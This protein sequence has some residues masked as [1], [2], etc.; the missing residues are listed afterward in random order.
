MPG[1]NRKALRILLPI[2]AADA[3]VGTVETLC[4][5]SVK[6]KSGRKQ[7]EAGGQKEG[8]SRIAACGPAGPRQRAPA[9][10]LS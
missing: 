3:L 7:P 1:W 2:V 5:M 9:P 10:E 4:A 6:P 8:L